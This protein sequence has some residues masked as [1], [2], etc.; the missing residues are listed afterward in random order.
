M[1]S[2]TCRGDNIQK[3]KKNFEEKRREA[4]ELKETYQ[5]LL[6][7]NLQKDLIIR[8]LKQKIQANK[9]LNFKG[10]LSIECIN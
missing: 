10:V 6:V 9:F 3:L 5:N 2:S 1:S 4:R 8:Q 7:E